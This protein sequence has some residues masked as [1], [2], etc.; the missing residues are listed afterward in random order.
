MIITD[1]NFTRYLPQDWVFLQNAVL[2]VLNVDPD[3]N[4]CWPAKLTYTF[5][6]RNTPDQVYW[7]IVSPAELKSRWELDGDD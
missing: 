4:G 1:R 5:V 3:D 6:T 2:E 7:K